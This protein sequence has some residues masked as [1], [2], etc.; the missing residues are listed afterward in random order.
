M[1]DSRV[2]IF[3]NEEKDM[4]PGTMQEKS[5]YFLKTRICKPEF[6]APLHIEF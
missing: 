2:Q 1:I 3:E 5:N 4:E 6:R